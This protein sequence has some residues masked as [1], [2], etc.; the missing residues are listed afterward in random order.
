MKKWFIILTLIATTLTAHAGVVGWSNSGSLPDLPFMSTFF[1]LSQSNVY[2]AHYA[3]LNKIHAALENGTFDPFNPSQ[4]GALDHMPVSNYVTGQVYY[5]THNDLIPGEYYPIFWF[6]V[7]LANANTLLMAG[8]DGNTYEYGYFFEITSM[9]PDV[10]AADTIS[11]VVP[12]HAD[13]HPDEHFDWVGEFYKPIPE[14]A[15]SLLVLGGAAVVL[16]RRRRK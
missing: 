15:T 10:L 9:Y 6:E 3:D 1:D 12:T 13:A 8:T 11:N 16:L 5:T 2:V 14:P 7:W 4:N